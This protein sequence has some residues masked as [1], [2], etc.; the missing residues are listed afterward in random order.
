MVAGRNAVVEALREQVPASTLYLAAGL[1]SDDRVKESIRL[2][3]DAGIPILEG[4]RT[5]LDRITEGA[6]H[7]GVALQVPAYEYARPEDLLRRD[8]AAPLVVVLDGVTDP[9]NLGAV[10]RSTSAF[11]GH[12]VVVSERRAAGM[13]AAAWKSSAGTAARTPVARATNL[14]RTLE[15]YKAAGVFVVGLD[16]DGTLDVD[17]LEMATEPLAL[18]VG[19][20]GRGLSRLVRATC[21][22]V[23][24]IPMAGSTE[25]LNAG[26]AAGVALYEIARRRRP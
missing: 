17:Q 3:A 1:E 13:T 19:A 15:A 22:L 2:A 24:R 21:D 12:G 25:S 16:A 20:E 9:R 11:G 10:V 7:Q 26:V 18:V 5:D 14:T 8:A 4:S 23:V 6:A